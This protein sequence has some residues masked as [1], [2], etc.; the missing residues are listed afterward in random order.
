MFTVSLS[1]AI[2]GIIEWWS[3]NWSSMRIGQGKK[4]PTSSA[5]SSETSSQKD[6]QEDKASGSGSGKNDADWSDTQKEKMPVSLKNADTD[7]QLSAIE[8]KMPI[9][10]KKEWSE[11]QKGKMPIV[12]GTLMF[13]QMKKKGGG[14]ENQITP[15]TTVGPTPAGTTPNLSQEDLKMGQSG[16]SSGPI[17]PS[18]NGPTNVPPDM[19]KEA[20][21]K[22][23]EEEIPL[24]RPVLV[25]ALQDAL[26][27]VDEE[28]IPLHRPVLV[29]AHQ[30]ALSFV[31]NI[32]MEREFMPPAVLYMQDNDFV[33][34]INRQLAISPDIFV[35]S[36]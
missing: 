20:C 26:S 22:I 1:K 36:D 29:S 24:Q 27:L 32:F 17:S 8:E 15:S 3:R 7:A 30:D 10:L 5:N 21:S 31:D 35:E 12:D 14:A 6:L 2:K 9:R 23:N 19:I 11:I 28:E 33:R 34:D 18:S 4:T 16:Q 13:D 25:S